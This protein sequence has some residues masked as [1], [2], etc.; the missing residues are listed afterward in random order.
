MSTTAQMK[1]RAFGAGGITPAQTRAIFAAA[2]RIGMEL[3]DVRA[4]TPGGSIKLLSRLQASDL[5][6]RLNASTEYQHPRKSPRAPRRPKSVYRIA[7]PPQLAKIESLRI[8][9]DWTSEGLTGWLSERHHGDGR[10]MTDIQSS[11]DRQAVVQLLKAV[12]KRSHVEPAEA[13]Q[14]AHTSAEESLF[15]ASS[16]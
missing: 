14:A 15:E 9:L 13:I 8:E 6:D 3:D 4:M 2:R 11:S 16:K 12:V 10:A 7:T 1:G 5:L